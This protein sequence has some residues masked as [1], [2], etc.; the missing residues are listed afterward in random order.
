VCVCHR[1]RERVCGQ[2]ER[3]CVA[4]R[5]IESVRTLPRSET[6][7]ASPT[8]GPWLGFGVEGLWFMVYGLWFMVYGL[9]FQG[10]GFRV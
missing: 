5:E 8:A 10:L 3:V 1:E 4:S 2:R 9:W 6:A 7:A